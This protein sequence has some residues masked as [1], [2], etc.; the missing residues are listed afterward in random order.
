[1]YYSQLI[2]V[3]K[4]QITR[5]FGTC[6]LSNAIDF[7]YEQETQTSAFPS[8]AVIHSFLLE[9]E[10]GDIEEPLIRLFIYKYHRLP[11]Y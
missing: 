1:M 8:L 3:G 10:K 9:Q 6:N 7:F 2:S 4:I 5:R 11:F